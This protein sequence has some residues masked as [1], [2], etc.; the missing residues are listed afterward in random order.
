[1][2][3][4]V[5]NQEVGD[6][7]SKRVFETSDIYDSVKLETMRKSGPAPGSI[8][9]VGNPRL[10]DRMAIDHVVM[11]NQYERRKAEKPTPGQGAVF[12]DIRM[13]VAT[14]G[15]MMDRYTLVHEV[16]PLRGAVAG[17][18]VRVYRVMR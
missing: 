6:R 16:R 15:D 1:M 5:W 18:V 2:N 10:V 3:S 14:Y 12:A 11:S 9:E 17:P 7:D 13:Q 8:G 4:G